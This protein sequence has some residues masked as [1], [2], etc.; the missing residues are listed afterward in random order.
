MS[1]F[2]FKYKIFPSLFL[3]VFCVALCGILEELWKCFFSYSCKSLW[4]NGVAKINVQFV[5]NLC[6]WFLICF[7]FV[8]HWKIVFKW[9]LCQGVRNGDSHRLQLPLIQHKII[10]RVRQFR[11]Q[12][13]ELEL[14]TFTLRNQNFN[15]CTTTFIK[16]GTL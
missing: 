3:C 5:Y 13:W 10:R 1:H 4:S 9:I 16:I 15:N 8:L 14:L 12:V 6:C 11:L 2:I 7:F